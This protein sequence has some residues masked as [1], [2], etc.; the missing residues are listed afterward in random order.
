MEKAIERERVLLQHLCPSSSSHNF[1]L[2]RSQGYG[3]LDCSRSTF[4][5][6]LLSF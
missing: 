4:F 6:R 2:S 5:F 1:H 3:I